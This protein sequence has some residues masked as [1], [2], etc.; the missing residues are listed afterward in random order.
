MNQSQFLGIIR[1]VVAP[2]LTYTVGKGWFP[3]SVAADLSAL[4]VTLGTALWTYFVH[5]DENK[6]A[7]VTALSPSEQNVA[8]HSISDGAKM[9]A[10]E[11]LPDVRRIVVA[12]DARDGVA[13]A[14]NDPS[15]PKVVMQ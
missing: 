4:A 15:R 10:V 1:A 14:A 7:E 9:A 2:A 3:E 5:T 6:V 13:T 11:A 8:F 12:P